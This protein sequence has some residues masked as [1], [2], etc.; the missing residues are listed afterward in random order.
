[1]EKVKEYFEKAKAWCTENP[2]KA[3]VVSVAV[4]AALYMLYT[5]VTSKKTRR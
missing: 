3:A 5:K 2:S 1:V 4:L